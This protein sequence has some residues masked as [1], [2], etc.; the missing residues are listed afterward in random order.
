[1]AKYSVREFADLLL[2][3]PKDVHVYIGRGVIVY[4]EN[5][6]IDDTNLVN[7]KFIKSRKVYNE[8]NG[9]TNIDFPSE[10]KEVRSYNSMQQSFQKKEPEK[11]KQTLNK[12]ISENVELS[13]ELEKLKIEKLKEEIEIARLKKEKMSGESIPLDYA[14]RVFALHFKNIASEF[15]NAT[16][17]Y[18]AVIVDKL[19]GS[20]KEL[21][22]FRQVLKSVVNTAIDEARKMS[23]KDLDVVITKEEGDETE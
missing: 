20:R 22:E 12:N 4:D 15:Y 7:M 10:A 19:K 13:N 6:K 5:K 14:Q 9:K 16:D 2:I 1:M 17:N 18:T 21:A 3:Q 8:R 23:A 11:K